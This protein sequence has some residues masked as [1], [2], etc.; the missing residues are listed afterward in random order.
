MLVP[1]DRLNSMQFDVT[2]STRIRYWGG[3]VS[4]QQC[5]I[6]QVTQWFGTEVAGWVAALVDSQEQGEARGRWRFN[7]YNARFAL[8]SSRCA[9]E[10]PTLDVAIFLATW[11]RGERHF[12][13]SQPHGQRP[14][15]L[16]GQDGQPQEHARREGGAGAQQQATRAAGA[17]SSQ[18]SDRPTKRSRQTSLL[19]FFATRK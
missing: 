7:T 2:G 16:A 13:G 14:E 4:R 3:C 15:E 12:L 11:E 19:D 1:G 8:L 9:A 6:R 10:D 18:T 5:S 17:E